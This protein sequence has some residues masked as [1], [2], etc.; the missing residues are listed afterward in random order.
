M[1]GMHVVF[2]KETRLSILCFTTPN[3]ELASDRDSWSES[4]NSL[5]LCIWKYMSTYIY[6]CNNNEKR[7]HEFESKQRWGYMGVLGGRRRKG[8]W[9]N[10]IVISKD[11]R[12]KKCILSSL[13]KGDLNRNLSSYK[14]TQTD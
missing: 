7:G 5:F 1:C 12:S 4:L 13:I 2:F 6:V 14:K 9:W 10:Y 11:K 8:K 3:N